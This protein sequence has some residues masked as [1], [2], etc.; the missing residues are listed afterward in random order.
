MR[1]PR[2]LIVIIKERTF[3]ILQRQLSTFLM[4]HISKSLKHPGNLS[5]VYPKANVSCDSQKSVSPSTD[6]SK[7]C[8][9]I[10][11]VNFYF[12]SLYY[13]PPNHPINHQAVTLP[14]MI[15]FFFSLLAHFPY[16]QMSGS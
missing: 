3:W 5:S 16:Y 14:L 4:P 1:I 2:G 15:P 8:I 11:E 9:W 13:L 12:L 7:F 10:T 6:F